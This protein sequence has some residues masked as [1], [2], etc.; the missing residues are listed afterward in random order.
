MFLPVSFQYVPEIYE[1]VVSMQHPNVIQMYEL[2]DDAGQEF[3]Y[4]LQASSPQRYVA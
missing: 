4:L 1:A 2:M 3:I